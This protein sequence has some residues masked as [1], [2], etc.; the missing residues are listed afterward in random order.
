MYE[1]NKSTLP[2]MHQKLYT[3]GWNALT[4]LTL[5]KIHNILCTD[6]IEREKMKIG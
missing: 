2:K 5:V 3:F 1:E 6:A 4:I